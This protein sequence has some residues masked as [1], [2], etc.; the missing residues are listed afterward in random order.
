VRFDPPSFRLG[1]A[2]SG[3]TLLALIAGAVLRRRQRA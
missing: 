2:T 1:L 3:A